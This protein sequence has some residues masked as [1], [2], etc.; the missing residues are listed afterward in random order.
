MHLFV[1]S[2]LESAIVLG[3][4]WEPRRREN[5]LLRR[6]G[7]MVCD[8]D[9]FALDQITFRSRASRIQTG[10]PFHLLLSRSS[11]PN[12]DECRNRSRF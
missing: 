11:S 1:R 2:L 8:S 5:E 7:S 4:I 12:D 6:L 10:L 9:G 3:R